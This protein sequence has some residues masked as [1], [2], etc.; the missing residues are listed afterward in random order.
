MTAKVQLSTTYSDDRAGA[1]HGR[2]RAG[3]GSARAG[4]VQGRCKAV[5]KCSCD[6]TGAR[7]AVEGWRYLSAALRVDS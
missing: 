1:S 5:C 2:C 4:P 7:Q 6:I 3:Q